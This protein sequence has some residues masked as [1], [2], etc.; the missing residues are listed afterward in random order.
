MLSFVLLLLACSTNDV[1]DEL[2][3]LAEELAELAE[4]VDDQAA[5]IAAL[6]AENAA[7]L[8]ELESLREGGGAEGGDAAP[9]LEYTLASIPKSESSINYSQF[10]YAASFQ[11]IGDADEVRILQ[12]SGNSPSYATKFT[13]EDLGDAECENLTW[14]GGEELSYRS[15][16][17]EAWRGASYWCWE[18]EPFSELVQTD[19]ANPTRVAALT[20]D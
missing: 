20:C 3:A 18:V 7:L 9:S 15:F 13:T 6:E 4:T 12:H 5:L 19:C 11:V 16:V 8:T 10:D 1:N 17:I 2:D 14:S